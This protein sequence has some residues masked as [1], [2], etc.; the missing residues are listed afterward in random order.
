MPLTLEQI[1]SLGALL[2]AAA[3]E[4][5]QQNAQLRPIK[6]GH[7]PVTYQALAREVLEA[8]QGLSRYGLQRGDRVAIIGETS[9]EWAVTDWACHMLGLPTAPIY[10]TLGPE[11]AMHIVRDSGAKLVIAQTD[12][13]GAKISGIPVASMRKDQSLPFFGAP[14]Q[15][16]DPMTEEQIR[17]RLAEVSR[18]DLATIIYTSGTTGQAKGAMLDHNSFLWLVDQVRHTVDITE[19]DVLLSFLPLAHIFERFCG[20]V[21]TA[22]R[23]SC[24]AFS[25]SLASLSSDMV[26]VQPTIMIAVPR[27]LESVQNKIVAGVKKQKPLSQKLFAM[28]MEAAAAKREGKFAPLAPV[29]DKVVGSKIRAKTGG[30]LRFFVSGGAALPPHVN[31]FYGA[32]GIK[33]LQGYGL[34]ETCAATCLNSERDPRLET[35]GQAINGLELKIA[36]DGEILVRGPSV[37]MGYHNLPAETAAVIDAEGW[38][39]TGDIGVLEDGHLRITDRK[40]DLIIL[41]NGKNIAPQKI[42][43]LLRESPMIN[44][45]VLFG[46]GE[47]GLSA[48]IVPEFDALRAWLKESDPQAPSATEELAA[49]PRVVTRIKEEV[50]AVNARLADFEKVKQHRLAPHPFSI[51]GGE[52]TPSMKVKRPVV[53]QIYAELIEP[54]LGK[55]G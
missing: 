22:S 11:D 17:A 52:L 23:G 44:E 43:G 45:A 2:L 31:A 27:F 26:T 32:L 14:G 39:S 24:V 25:A 37:M 33:V 29:L 19:H 10:P 35:V 12:E 53:R 50:A 54:M 18:G 42:E 3:E 38:F 48:L 4:W 41:G 8:A 9:P 49:H 28:T 13:L 7:E 51:D 15:G 20:Q 21:L 47:P 36:A 1:P 40:K 46:E 6:G 34:T 30:K 55:S 16:E 5:P